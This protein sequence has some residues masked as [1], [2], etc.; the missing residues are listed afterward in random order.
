MDRSKWL[1]RRL[2]REHALEVHFQLGLRAYDEGDLYGL[3][4]HRAALALLPRGGG[5]DSLEF[6]AL[7]WRTLWLEGQRPEAVEVA[8]ELVLRF[9]DDADAVLELA[10]ILVDLE[11]TDEA[12]E[13]LVRGTADNPA[14]VELWY[15]LGLAAERGERYDLRKTAFGHVWRLEHDVQPTHRLWLSEQRFMTIVE[16][17][18][19][20]LPPPARAALGN[21]AILVEDYPES[22]IVDS[23]IGDPRILGL[24][25]GPTRA[26]EQS[27]SVVPQQ[28]S[29]ITLYR[30]NIERSCRSA[31]EAE[32]QIGITVLH[33]IGHYL[34]LDEDA[35]HA[36]GLG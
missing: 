28:P 6:L 29:R 14:D 15:E 8:R 1:N 10:Q 18:L 19:A 26:E 32:E 11:Q 13:V 21:V 5:H 33:E 30:Y 34:G 2:T 24:F 7:D 9:P 23:E 35:L 31:E 17:T 20:R 27:I 12:I 22:W 3:K 16:E 4:R 25:D 36:R